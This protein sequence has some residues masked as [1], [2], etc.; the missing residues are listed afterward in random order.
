MI[1]LNVG[2][3]Q[4]ELECTCSWLRDYEEHLTSHINLT[5]LNEIAISICIGFS[6]CITYDSSMTFSIIVELIFPFLLWK[7]KISD[8]LFHFEWDCVDAD[9][10]HVS[11]EVADLKRNQNMHRIR[12]GQ[13]SRNRWAKRIF[14]ENADPRGLVVDRWKL[15][16]NQKEEG[17]SELYEKSDDSVVIFS[18]D[19]F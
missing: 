11:R 15:P 4:V 14:H 6:I 7:I 19:C 2:I 17:K 13:W 12:T 8:I 5:K 10:W 3:L 16:M 18:I 9:F 1:I